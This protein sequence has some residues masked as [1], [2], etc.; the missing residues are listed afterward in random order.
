MGRVL[1]AGLVGGIVLF[2]WGAVSWMAIG[3]HNT[4]GGKLANESAVV[5]VLKD[6]DN[7]SGVY[8]L[9]GHSR[10]EMDE[11]AKET[12][13]QAHRDGPVGV[14][15]Y[16]PEGREPMPAMTFVQG[17]VI[18]FFA[19]VI[20]ALLLSV[21]AGSIK[22]Y[23]GRVAFVTALGLFVGVF[24]DLTNWNFMF[25]PTDWTVVALIDH[26]VTWLL[27]GLAIAAIVKAKPAAS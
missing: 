18:D 9:P 8:W 15:V 27:A 2:V 3:W 19:A 21:A 6:G 17:F 16:H 1:V 14:I 5:D 26:V 13:A 10:E 20:A 11:A 12:Y 22:G 4:S 7:G 25:F 24:A 23:L